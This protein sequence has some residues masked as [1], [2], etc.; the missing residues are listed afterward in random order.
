MR[1]LL[2]VNKLNCNNVWNLKILLNHLL[3]TSNLIYTNF[4]TKL[5]LSRFHIT[6]VNHLFVLEMEIIRLSVMGDTFTL[7][8]SWTLISGISRS[9][10]MRRTTTTTRLTY[11]TALYQTLNHTHRLNL[12]HRKSLTNSPD[13][14]WLTFIST[15]SLTTHQTRPSS[16]EVV[17]SLTSDVHDYGLTSPLLCTCV[18]YRGHHTII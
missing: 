1:Y 5:T 8:V 6:V 4:S 15:Q 14:S 7:A 9:L 18:A 17:N 10:W 11:T 16:P 2:Q 13:A 12:P 3:C